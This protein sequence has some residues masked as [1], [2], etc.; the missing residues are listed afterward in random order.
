MEKEEGEV[1]EEDGEINGVAEEAKEVVTKEF[2][3]DKVTTKGESMDNV[4]P[5]AVDDIEQ[6][7]RD[8]DQG[9]FPAD[10]DQQE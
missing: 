7:A 4:A 3:E 6:D 9:G 1:E 8:A 5:V 2:K 10:G